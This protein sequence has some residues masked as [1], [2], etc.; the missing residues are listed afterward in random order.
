[1]EHFGYQCR[2]SCKPLAEEREGFVFC[3]PPLSAEA[4][5][6]TR[7]ESSYEDGSVFTKTTHRSRPDSALPQ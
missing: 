7:Y 4:Q 5:G 2:V 1:M 6:L 3:V